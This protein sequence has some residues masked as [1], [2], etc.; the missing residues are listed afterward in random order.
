M[1]I[2]LAIFKDKFE[3]YTSLKPFYEKY[4]QFETEKSS[5]EYN[6]SRK[7]RPYKT[8]EIEL[9]RLEVAKSVL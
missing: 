3:A 9:Y 4:P 2:I 8:H 6:L 1:R 7:N 5:I